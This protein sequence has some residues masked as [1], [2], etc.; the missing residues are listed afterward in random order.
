MRIFDQEQLSID[1]NVFH[2]SVKATLVPLEFHNE[3]SVY[4]FEHGLLVLYPFNKNERKSYG[5]FIHN[6]ISTIITSNIIKNLLSN[7]NDDP[8]NPHISI[9]AIQ[10]EHNVDFCSTFL[11]M[12]YI[13]IA[14][15]SKNCYNLMA[16]ISK[17]QLKT[18]IDQKLKTW[19]ASLLSDFSQDT[20]LIPIPQWLH[21]IANT[22]QSCSNQFNNEESCQ[23]D[24][25][26]Q[27]R[28]NV[29][30]NSNKSKKR[31]SFQKN[32]YQ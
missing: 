12:V 5:C 28:R 11:L 20:T 1:P 8:I 17:L 13:Y 16:S 32:H 6:N 19:L 23:N 15:S 18:E 14:H 27:Q 3:D 7:T 30:T 25:K 9:S 10:V 21:Q 4:T 24:G 29:G 2:N 22:A 26:T 31:G